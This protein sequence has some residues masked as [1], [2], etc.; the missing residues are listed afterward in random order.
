MGSPLYILGILA[1]AAVA[2]VL[3]IGIGGFGVGGEF[4]RKN[5]NKMMRLRIFF[6]FV[7]VVLMVAFV[8]F[9]GTGN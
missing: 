7:A 2:I 1:M 5:G 3:A 8:Y 9:A 6:Q 4:N